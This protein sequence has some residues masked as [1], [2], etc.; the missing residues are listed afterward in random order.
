MLKPCDAVLISVAMA[1]CAAAP[2]IAAP[3]SGELSE[4]EFTLELD[5]DALAALA[6]SEAVSGGP[7]LDARL[8][9]EAETVSSNGLRLGAVMAAA[10]RT[11]DG[12]RGLQ[13]RLQ[14]EPAT[15]APVGLVTGLGGSGI[16]AEHVAGLVQADAFVKSRSLRFTLDLDG[17]RRSANA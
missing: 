10:A 16:A 5:I 9:L 8:R 6:D 14:A 1:W 13:P 2:A 17:P 15:G 3:A 11:R 7:H 4:V 12:R